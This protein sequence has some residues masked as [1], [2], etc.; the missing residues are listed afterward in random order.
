MLFLFPLLAPDP[1]YNFYPNKMTR[2]STYQD[3]LVVVNIKSLF[4]EGF[5]YCIFNPLV[6]NSLKGSMSN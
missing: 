2:F 5:S 6:F 4:G 3:R 1:E